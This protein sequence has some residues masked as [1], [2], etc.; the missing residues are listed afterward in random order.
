MLSRVERPLSSPGWGASAFLVLWI[1]LW[2]FF[3]IAVVEPAARLHVEVA[4]A[5][6]RA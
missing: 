3:T 1:A 5:E 4:R 2:A 6:Q